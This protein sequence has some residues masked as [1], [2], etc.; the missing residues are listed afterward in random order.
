MARVVLLGER[1]RSMITPE[2]FVRWPIRSEMVVRDTT[3]I[4]TQ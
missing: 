3:G 4:I 1:S 2:P